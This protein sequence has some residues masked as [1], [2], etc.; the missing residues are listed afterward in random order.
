MAKIPSYHLYRLGSVLRFTVNPW[1][2]VVYLQQSK[3]F[4]CEGGSKPMKIH[5]YQRHF[6]V[7]TRAPFAL[8]ISFYLNPNIT[9]VTLHLHSNYRMIITG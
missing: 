4:Q 7:N 1:F 8:G 6:E 2:T 9:T 5:N 3:V